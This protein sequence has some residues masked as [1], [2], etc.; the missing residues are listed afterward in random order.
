MRNLPYEHFY[1]DVVTKP[2]GI[3]EWIE[4]ELIC[5]YKGQVLRQ[6]E[7]VTTA[8]VVPI[9][10]NDGEPYRDDLLPICEFGIDGRPEYNMLFRG[11]E[12]KFW[13][14]SSNRT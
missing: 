3:R 10:Y 8:I 11:V 13:Q 7:S 2:R 14:L 9:E 6:E 5:E 12:C 4:L 1:C